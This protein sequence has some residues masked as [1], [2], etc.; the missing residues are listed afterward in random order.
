VRGDDAGDVRAVPVVVGR[1]VADADARQAV[2]ALVGRDRAEQIRWS[3]SIPLS[4]IIGPF[5]G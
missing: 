5:G 4:A 2:R 3:E 1:A